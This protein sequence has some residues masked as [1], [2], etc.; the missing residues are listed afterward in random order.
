MPPPY[1]HQTIIPGFT[2]NPGD[3]I[4]GEVW[5]GQDNKG[6]R[7]GWISILNPANGLGKRDYFLWPPLGT[8]QFAGESVEWI[9]E[10][11]NE[12]VP[13]TSLPSFSACSFMNAIGYDQQG[14]PIG[15]PKNGLCVNISPDQGVSMYTEVQLSD[16]AV[17]IV[18]PRAGIF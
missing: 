2:I 11:P 1:I 16:G 13:K 5:Y 18:D 9:L 6:S 8:S 12:G 4:T 3:Q 14:Q 17:T 15:N 10:A 7:G